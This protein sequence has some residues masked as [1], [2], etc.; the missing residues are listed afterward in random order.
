[1]PPPHATTEVIAMH[2][3]KIWGKPR[4]IRVLFSKGWSARRSVF[5]SLD[6][7]EQYPKEQFGDDTSIEIPDEEVE[8]AASAEILTKLC[9]NH[10]KVGVVQILSYGYYMP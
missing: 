10:T 7:C 5:D 3:S 9:G 4:H 8:D 1:M 6:S 2:N